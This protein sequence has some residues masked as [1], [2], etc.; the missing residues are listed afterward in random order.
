MFDNVYFVQMYPETVNETNQ[1]RSLI[2]FKCA[3]MAFIGKGGPNKYRIW[4]I[5]SR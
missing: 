5:D 1:M 2:N 3:A 4:I